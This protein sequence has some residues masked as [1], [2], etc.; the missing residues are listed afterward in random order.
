MFENSTIKDCI[1]GANPSKILNGQA[2]NQ[3]E[4]TRQV[5]K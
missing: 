3:K 5:I 2:Y 4:N 1:F